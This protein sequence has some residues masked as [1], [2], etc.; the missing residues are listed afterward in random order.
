MLY[1]S[2]SPLLQKLF[3]SGSI[4]IVIYLKKIF[5]PKCFHSTIRGSGLSGPIP[6]EI[7]LLKNLTDL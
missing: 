1:D 4:S 7:S 5:L 3:A 6:A 2:F